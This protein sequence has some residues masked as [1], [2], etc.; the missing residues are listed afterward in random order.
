MSPLA[1]KNIFKKSWLY[2]GEWMECDI[3]TTW[4]K[5]ILVHVKPWLQKKQRQKLNIF[6]LFYELWFVVEG[7]YGTCRSL[8]STVIWWVAL[9]WTIMPP[10]LFLY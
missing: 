6:I 3:Q 9:S 10:L 7:R 5:I 4:D 1:L 8:N 2:I